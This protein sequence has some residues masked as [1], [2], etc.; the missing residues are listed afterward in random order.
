MHEL[1]FLKLGGSLITDK[2]RE[3]TAREDVIRRAARET[4][5]DTPI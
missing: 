4:P 2:S 1:V 5:A 3:A